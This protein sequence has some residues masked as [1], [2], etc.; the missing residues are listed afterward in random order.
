MAAVD[1][2]GFLAVGIGLLAGITGVVGSVH[3]GMYIYDNMPVW[4]LGGVTKLDEAL[5]AECPT[6]QDAMVAGDVVRKL[7]CGHVFHK[8]CTRGGIDKWLREN[9]LSCPNC[10]KRALSVRVLPWPWNKQRPLPEEEE[11]EN[12]QRPLPAPASSTNAG[13]AP[14]GT[15]V[16]A[17]QG[18]L[19]PPPQAESGPPRSEEQREN[20][21]PPSTTSSRAS[22]SPAP[23]DLEE[24]PLLSEISK[25]RRS[26][27][28]SNR[29]GGRER[30]RARTMADDP[31][32]PTGYLVGTIETIAGITAVIGS[33]HLG[34]YIYENMPVW[35][36]SGVTKLDETLVA[37]CPTCQDAMVAGDI[38]RKLSCGH[39]F[40]KSCTRG[41]IEKWLR[42]N[43]LS[44]P[45]CRKRARSLRALPWP[46]NKRRPLPEEE[47]Q[48][49]P[50]PP[51]DTSSTNVGFAQEGTDVEAQ[52][53]FQPPPPPQTAASDSPRSEEQREQHPPPPP[54]ET[55]PRASSSSGLEE[56]LLHS[57]A[58]P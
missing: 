14:E 16:E 20:P 46:W 42:E 54:S 22:S 55:S 10:R 8:S 33:V 18:Q 15:D 11:Q 2:N 17:H 39:V 40:H 56:P 41:G 26:S 35:M 5:D 30:A 21:P 24:E 7:S 51:P 47:E 38:V 49:N 6:C 1:P 9:K 23:S 31:I 25:A 27:R 3:L 32:D 48:E 12:T 19:L 28:G 57:S 44:C 34:I 58:S 13:F 4:M 36:L 45:N 29:I 52:G 50:P 37:E 53:E 43:K